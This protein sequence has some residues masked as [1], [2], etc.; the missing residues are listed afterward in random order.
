MEAY[1]KVESCPD[2]PQVRRK[3]T[4][5]E[6]YDDSYDSDMDVVRFDDDPLSPSL[7]MRSVA[8]KRPKTWVHFIAAEEE[9]WDYA[10]ALLSTED[11]G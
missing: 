4:E 5:E 3:T 1:V 10:P 11:S 7:Q 8:K 6:D 9:E 2:K